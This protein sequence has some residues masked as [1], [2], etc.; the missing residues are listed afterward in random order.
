MLQVRFT[1]GR[2]QGGPSVGA[3]PFPL[4]SLQNQKYFFIAIWRL[5]CYAFLLFGGV[6]LFFPH[7][8]EPFAPWGRG[9]FGYFFYVLGRGCFFSMWEALF[10]TYVGFFGACPILGKLLRAP[11][12]YP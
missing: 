4:P 9:Y 6:W 8:G 3:R 5:S 11:M 2:P 1:H 10:Y 12:L 7:V